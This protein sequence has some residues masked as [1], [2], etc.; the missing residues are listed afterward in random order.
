MIA[1]VLGLLLATTIVGETV[2]LRPRFL[3]NNYKQNII[4]MCLVDGANLSL[5]INGKIFVRASNKSYLII[6][7]ASYDNNNSIASSRYVYIPLIEEA[8]AKIQDVLN[9]VW[10]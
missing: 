5:F 2:W 10:A 7:Q 1:D 6:S 4:S 9:V 3:T 8:I